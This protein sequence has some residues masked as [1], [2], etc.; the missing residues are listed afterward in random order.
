MFFSVIQMAEDRASA[1]AMVEMTMG[2]LLVLCVNRMWRERRFSVRG[3]RNSDEIGISKF[4]RSFSV[5]S[6][7]IVP[8]HTVPPYSQTPIANKKRH[9]VINGDFSLQF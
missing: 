9:P 4:L 6:S 8:D 7:K 1:A 3:R 2:K 5:C